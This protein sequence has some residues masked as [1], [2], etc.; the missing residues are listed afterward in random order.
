MTPESFSRALTTLDP[1]L[2]V[3]WGNVICQWVIDRT[4][5][6]GPEEM[7][8][9]RRRSA[10]LDGWIRSGTNTKPETISAH[11]GV[12][13][14]Y[15][16]AS[17]GRR[18]ILFC[19]ELSA[20]VY[21]DLCAA[22]IRR[23]GGYSRLADEIE[24]AEAKAEEAKRKDEENR[25]LI[26]ASETADIVNFLSR[27]RETKLLSGERR[28]SVLLGSEHKNELRQLR[29]MLRPDAV[30]PCSSGV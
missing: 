6:I 10:R 20:A 26:V 22:D 27:K 8:F 4:G 21:N 7:S 16:S 12:T 28:L 13:E 5:V 23:Y 18:V 17:E 19:K 2:R 25:G 9:L 11:K 1:L 24:K 15:L 29:N 14:E 30:I 3:R